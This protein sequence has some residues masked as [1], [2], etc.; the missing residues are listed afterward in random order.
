MAYKYVVDNM[1]VDNYR[2][3]GRKM[4]KVK[5]ITI[6]NTGNPSSTALNER[7][8]LTNPSNKRQASFHLAVDATHVVQCMP[9]NEVAF[10]AGDGRGD[11]NYA[12]IGIEI[13]ESG[14]YQKNVQNAVE[15]TAKLLKQHGLGVQHL[16]R[17]WDWSK[18]IC[19]RKMY[20]NG[21]WTGWTNFKSMVEKEMKGGSTVSNT[22]TSTA[23]RQAVVEIL[24]DTDLVNSKGQKIRTLK[25]GQRYKGYGLVNVGGDQYVDIKSVK[26]L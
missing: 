20:D 8:W 3:I 10:H 12:S 22:N 11:G 26:V 9:L 17:H 2:R 7:G 4:N 14:N 16:R 15:L 18:K 6:H 21:K 5:F 13:C 1:P 23:N 19:P 25:K 24:N